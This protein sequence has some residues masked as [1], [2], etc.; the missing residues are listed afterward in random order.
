MKG[1]FVFVIRKVCVMALCVLFIGGAV[2]LT[3]THASTLEQQRAQLESE[4]RVI[5]AE[6]ALREKALEKQRQQT[7]S[8]KGELDQLRSEISLRKKEISAKQNLIGSLSSEIN[9]KNNTIN[10]LQSEIEREKVVLAYSI[11][12]QNQLHNFSFL[13]FWLGGKQLS[14]SVQDQYKFAYVQDDL[15]DSYRGVIDLTERTHAE[16]EELETRK[17]EEADI[18]YELEQDKAKVERKE[19]EQEDLYTQSK[20]EEF[21]HQQLIN[22]RKQRIASIRAQLFELN[23][24]TEGALSFGEAY[25]L[26]KQAG[27]M[28]GI[29]PAFILAILKQETNIGKNVGTCNKGVGTKNWTQIM[30]G[31]T[32]NSWRDDQTIF[33]ALTKELGLNPDV[34]P[35]S[36]PLPSG[37]W[38]GA[39]GISQFIP[40]TWAEYGGMVERNGVWMYDSSKDRIR[41]ALG[42]NTMS[43]PW[44]HLHG[45]TA[46][47]LYMKD[48]GAGA[49]TYSKERDAAC[50]YYSGRGC[51]AP[52]VRNAFYGNAVMNHAAG[53]QQQIDFIEGR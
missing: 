52:N 22:Q 24:V 48:L 33:K 18:K 6:I 4:L 9:K 37:G 15:H 11:R 27:N 5:E 1:R 3:T 29:R 21:T 17:E 16:K 43:N 46:T 47:A 40:A 31:P 14:D 19:D 20:N 38:G 26:A 13:D 35:L 25:D 12:K 2:P 36:C 53:F 45:I 51:A 32:S 10:S 50:K 23:G 41:N 39:M 42:S 44:N 7:G 30:P 34:M 8:I 49:Q 28:T